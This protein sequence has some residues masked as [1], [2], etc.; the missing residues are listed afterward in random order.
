MPK[1]VG[2]KTVYIVHSVCAN[3]WFLIIRHHRTLF[4]A[5]SAVTTQVCKI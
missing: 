4:T 1:H 2:E 3:S 5:L